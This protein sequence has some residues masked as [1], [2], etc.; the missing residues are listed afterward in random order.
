M[1][2]VTLRRPGI[3]VF[4]LDRIL[5]QLAVGAGLCLQLRPHAV[6]ATI[7]KAV[8]VDRLDLLHLLRAQSV[9]CRARTHVREFVRSDGCRV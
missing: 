8:V 9:R 1:P 7:T 4:A 6:A 2:G 3:A 5:V